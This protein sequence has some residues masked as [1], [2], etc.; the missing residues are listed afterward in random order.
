MSPSRRLLD[1][2]IT[3]AY[4]V[5]TAFFAWTLIDEDGIPAAMWIASLVAAIVVLIDSGSRLFARRR[6]H[7]D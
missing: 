2:L 3:L 5:M 7:D 6:A 1:V 4:L